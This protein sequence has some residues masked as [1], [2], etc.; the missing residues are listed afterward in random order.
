[1][2]KTLIHLLPLADFLLNSAF[3]LIHPG[4]ERIP[5][6]FHSVNIYGAPAMY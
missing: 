3:Q 6:K 4:T 5:F 1:M 2:L